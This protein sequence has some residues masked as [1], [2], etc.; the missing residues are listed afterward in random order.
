ME[1]SGLLG[2]ETLLDVAAE[3]AVDAEAGGWIGG[4]HG[5]AA[6]VAEAAGGGVGEEVGVLEG[7]GDEVF[8]VGDVAV[9]TD[10]GGDGGG[11]A[12]EGYG[13]ID[14]VRTEV[15]KEAVGRAGLF[16]GVGTDE[17]AVA[18]HVREDLGDT[19]EGAFTM[20]LG[21][22]EEVVVEAAI[23]KGGEDFALFGG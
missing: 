9:V 12:E 16:P 21:E 3:G 13:L 1:E 7:D 11:G 14:E 5:C 2:V 18:I 8:D 4:E 6:G 20:E 17:G 10:G 22:G 19:A 23:V 15:K